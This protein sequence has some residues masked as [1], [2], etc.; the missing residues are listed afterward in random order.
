MRLLRIDDY[1]SWCVC[2]D[3]AHVLVD[4]W[5][6]GDL[7]V[8]PGWFFRRSFDE[9]DGHS[10][11]VPKCDALVITAPF[12][13]HLH[14]PSL[15]LLPKTVPVW[16]TQ[17]CVRALQKLGFKHVEV[18]AVDSSTEV[19]PGISMRAIPSGR[20]Y[21]DTSMGVMVGVTGEA[22]TIY[23]EPHTFDMESLQLLSD[24]PTVVLAPLEQVTLFS[25]RFAMGPG[26]LAEGLAL[27][28]AR[29][30]VPTGTDPQKARGLIRL[31]LRI[32]GTD[33]DLSEALRLRNARAQR[34][35]MM[36]GDSLSFVTGASEPELV[37]VDASP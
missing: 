22:P 6:V 7:N 15:S 21:D 11:G 28:D 4:P 30:Y 34:L 32:R 14:T 27:A 3:R 17:A 16:T 5:L 20:P 24:A 10:S 26:V 23:L 9:R 31:G 35:D 8:G 25:K 1:Q 13:D 37:R 2:T 33:K 19:V 12:G 36:A 29:Y 18:L